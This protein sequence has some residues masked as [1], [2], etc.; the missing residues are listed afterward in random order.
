MNRTHAKAAFETTVWLMAFWLLLATPA[1]ADVAMKWTDAQLTAFSDVIVTGRV[2][3]VSAGVDDRLGAI[4]SY[5]TLDVDRVL[6]GQVAERR[7]T[8]KQLG[9]HVGATAL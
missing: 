6:K 1:R 9:G 4:Y 8:I 3:G 7:I 2:V 5:V